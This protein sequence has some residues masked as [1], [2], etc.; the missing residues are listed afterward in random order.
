MKQKKLLSLL[1]SAA[2][3]LT[4]VIAPGSSVFAADNGSQMQ[5]QASASG[6]IAYSDV[7]WKLRGDTLTFTGKGGLSIDGD[8][9]EKYK[10]DI[11][12]IVVGKGITSLHVYMDWV[13]DKDTP[14][15]GVTHVT[16]PSTLTEITG[17]FHGCKNLT[18]INIP[19]SVKTIGE[20][21]FYECR[22]LKTVTGGKGVKSVAS[23]AFYGT[24]WLKSPGLHIL[25]KCCV[26]YG[27]DETNT[28][29]KIPE[30]IKVIISDAFSHCNLT[31]ITLPSTLKKIESF[32]FWGSENLK[33][34]TGGKNVTE[35]GRRAFD[36]TAWLKAQGDVAALEK[37]LVKY[38]GSAASYSV[39]AK[40]TAIAAE[41]FADN[42]TLESVN[43]EGSIKSVPNYAFARCENLKSVSLPNT[44]TTLAYGAFDGCAALPE[45]KLPSAL[46]KI[47]VGAFSECSSLAKVNVSNGVKNTKLTTLGMGAFLNC[48][49]L[50]SLT[51]PGGVAMIG[52]YAFGFSGKT[53]NLSKIGGTTVVGLKQTTAER[54]AKKNGIT[55]KSAA[56]IV[57][58]TPSVTAKKKVPGAVRLYEEVPVKISYS[59]VANATG[60]QIY[61]YDSL[62]KE[63][64]KAKSVGAKT[65]SVTLY[66]SK[67]FKYKVR[68]YRKIGSAYQYSSFS[69]ATSAIK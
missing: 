57:L 16:L 11:K 69:K 49:N 28:D 26:G 59:K 40:Y 3:V 44:V 19:A 23:D 51:I 47:D 2:L 41:A 68:A 53:W 67:G 14:F 52:D 43:F 12:K 25:G 63:W 46:K 15:A 5:A 56:G 66:G 33:T 48:D 34:V 20:Q 55:F 35:I 27:D 9:Y 64:T 1:L 38:S 32:A 29:V 13:G 60:Y 42:K 17:S 4:M 65:L 6:T 58:K 50:K 24:A 10:N 21:L 39:P 31:S 18:S 45:I 61:E 37:V 30:G 62:R 54:Y 8:D 22:A 7:K 36:G